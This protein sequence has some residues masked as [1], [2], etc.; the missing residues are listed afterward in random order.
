MPVPKA[1]LDPMLGSFRGMMQEV[2]AKGLS[3]PPVEAMRAALGR[4]EALGQEHHDLSAF[5]GQVMQEDLFASFSDAY[6]K[7]L[8]AAARPASAEGGGGGAGEASDPAAEDA[9]LLENTLAAYEQALAQHRGTEQEALFA[10]ALEKVIALGRSGVSY[11]VFLRRLEEEGLSDALNAPVA[12]REALA[13]EVRFACDAHDPPRLEEA[14]EQLDAYDG[15]VGESRFGA[16]DPLAIELTRRRIA[17]AHAPRRARWQ[18]IERRGERIL[19]DLDRWVDAFTDF[20]FYDERWRAPGAS[21]AQVRENIQRDQECQ[22][23]YLRVREELLRE[24][25]GIDFH[26]IFQAPPMT[27]LHVAHRIALSD[28]KI[29]VLV[30]AW[31]SCV[32][33]G[34]PPAELVARA[35]A[36]RQSGEHVR[37]TLGQ[38]A[39][40]PV[41]ERARAGA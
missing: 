17:H 20:A 21:D 22:P 14:L 10:P 4:M 38:K 19:D 26:G 28:A 2:E 32:P 13:A 24:S 16:P 1:M 18:A 5:Q 8:A 40:L 39:T 12:T 37:A 11:P 7:A 9:Q 29:A 15:L 41:P 30:D 31:P 3:G 23:G 27:N 25:F 36:L 33:G 6:G 35:E 34:R